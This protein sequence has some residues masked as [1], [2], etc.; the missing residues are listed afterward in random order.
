MRLIECVPN[1]SEGNNDDIINKISSE[2]TSVNNINLLD[3]DPGKDTNRTVITFAGSPEDVIEA[4][5]LAILKASELI[6]MTKH[7]GAHSRMGATDVCPLIPIKGVTVEECIE[8]SHK[9]AKRVSK[10]L[11][12]PV[13]M[14]E[15]SA[16]NDIRINLANIRKGE[17]EG[18]EQKI[19][20]NEWKP[21]YGE[22]K[23]NKKSGVTAIGVREFLIAYNVNLNTSNKKL[24][25]DIALDIRE[26]GRAKRDFNGKIIRNS[27]NEIIKLPG[28]LKF[29]KAVGWYLEE[30]NLAQVSMNLVNYKK[31]PLHK[32]FDEINNQAQKRGL[33]VTGSELVG[34]IPLSSMLDAGKYFL[35]K[36][37]QSTGVTNS[38]LIHIAIKSM[39]LDEMYEFKVNNKI[40]DYKIDN[41]IK[42]IDKK[43]DSFVDEISMDSPAPGGGSVS[44][45]AA[46]LASALISM[47]ANLTYSKDG[48]KKHKEET[49]IIA[50]KAQQLKNKFLELIDKDTDAFEA[51]MLSYRLPKKKSSDIKERKK[52][53]IKMTKVVTEVPLETLEMSLLALKLSVSTIK[54]GNKNCLSD[55]AVAGE[56]ACAAA[57]G[58]LYNVQINLLDLKNE[59]VYCQK[60]NQ[61]LNKIMKEV[62]QE[63]KVIKNFTKKDLYYE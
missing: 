28:S 47:V 42:L 45:L 35:E 38:Q 10:E 7:S 60:I 46:S 48:F 15:N 11:N 17:Y 41:K 50:N 53:I 4:A 21:D 33:R 58:A 59:K 20:K 29:V 12:I 25:S 31:T 61:K 44:A 51:L 36:Q 30:H 54:L 3:V 13:Y 6:D 34:L 57:Y 8:Y 32:V 37:G 19:K 14:Y 52:E 55:V 26:A 1:F 27:K 49:N 56:M 63:I 22:A 18:M 9:L 2:I 62:D 40:I 39:G 5:F 23:L 43:V 16:S 24:A